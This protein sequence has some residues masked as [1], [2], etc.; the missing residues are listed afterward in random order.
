MRPWE[1][2]DVGRDGILDDE[3]YDWL[4]VVDAMAGS[5]GTPVVAAEAD[6][7]DALEQ[8]RRATARPGGRHRGSRGSPA[9]RAVASTRP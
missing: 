1:R 7:L 8:A 5:G 2:A 4:G 6:V 9:L 3:T